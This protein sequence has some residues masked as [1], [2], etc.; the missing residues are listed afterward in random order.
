MN[1][2]LLHKDITDKILKCFYE[3]N[4]NLGYG[5]LEKI[6]KNAMH[7][8]P[9]SLGLKSELE[10]QIK[11]F[12]K[13]NLMGGFSADLTVED[14]VIVEVKT[15]ETLREEHEC[16]LINYLRA[17]SI[18]VGLLLNFGKKPEFKRKFFTNNL[19]KINQ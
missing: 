13:G 5:F 4:N 2:E 15:C 8:E 10:K 1:N 11:V 16:Q 7:F 3:V 14:S 6:Y 18:E 17:T 9:I 12:Y 19:K